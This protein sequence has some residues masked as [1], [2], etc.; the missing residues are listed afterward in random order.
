MSADESVITDGVVDIKKVKP[1]S[2]DPFGNA[3]F[4]VGD[5]VGSAFKD[6]MPL[7]A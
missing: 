1:I 6:G 5:K 3:Y 7:K 4:G 2:F